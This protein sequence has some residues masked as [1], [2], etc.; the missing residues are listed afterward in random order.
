MQLCCKNLKKKKERVK[1]SRGFSMSCGLVVLTRKNREKLSFVESFLLPA[2]ARL[3]RHIKSE[4]KFS[5]FSIVIGH[6]MKYSSAMSGRAER[7]NIWLS[8]MAHGPRC[9][10]SVR[11]EIEPTFFPSGPTKLSR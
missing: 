11:H 2:S 1:K 7:E 3:S 9:A 6:M 8:V 10:W 4:T 5:K